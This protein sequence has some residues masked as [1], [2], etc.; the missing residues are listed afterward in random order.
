[1]ASTP[2]DVYKVKDFDNQDCASELILAESLQQFVEE[3]N[4][5]FSILMSDL[6]VNESKFSSFH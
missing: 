6:N 1:M 3:G 2:L 5:F 4:K